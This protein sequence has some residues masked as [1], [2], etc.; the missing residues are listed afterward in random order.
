MKHVSLHVNQISFLKLY[1]S[2]PQ[3]MALVKSGSDGVNSLRAAA[4]VAVMA[5]TANTRPLARLAPIIKVDNILP[6]N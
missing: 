4:E 2:F 6:G 1:S 5:K 3:K